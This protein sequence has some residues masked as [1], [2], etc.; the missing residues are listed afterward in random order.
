VFLLNSRDPFVTATYGPSLKAK[1]IGTPY[2]KVT[3][4]ICLVPSPGV[5]RHALGFSPRAP[6]LVLGTDAKDPSSR[7]F[8]GLQGSAKPPYAEGYSCFCLI[9]TVTV[10]LRLIQLNRATA[11]LDLPRS[12]IREARVATCTS[13]VQDS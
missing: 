4:L 11:L 12:V 2:S 3:G 7:I 13:A 8:Q 9:L 10:L 6:V 1:A 5:T